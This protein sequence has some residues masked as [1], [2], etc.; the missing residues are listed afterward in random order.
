MKILPINNDP[1]IK[2]YT[3]HTYIDAIINNECTTGNQI[4]TIELLEEQMDQLIYLHGDV[5][6]KEDG[7]RI[8]VLSDPYNLDNSFTA[9]RR[10]K[11]T[12]TFIIGIEYQQ[13][14]NIW[15]NIGIFITDQENIGKYNDK[16]NFLNFCKGCLHTTNMKLL[17]LQH[18][19]KHRFPLYLKLCKTEGKL[20]GF[21]SYDMYSWINCFNEMVD[22]EIINNYYIGVN[23]G[24]SDNHYYN[25]LFSNYIQLMLSKSW[26]D[27]SIIPL[28]FYVM[29]Q[30]DYKFQTIHNLV[31]FKNENRN[32]ITD[33]NLNIIDY[34]IIQLNHDNYVEVL[35]NERYIPGRNGYLQQ[36]DRNHPN[37]IYGYNE[38]DKVFY[39]LGYNKLSKPVQDIVPFDV[40]QQAYDTIG[41]SSDIRM[42]EY[43]PDVSI[44]RM[45]VEEIA[46]G[47]KSYLN[48]SNSSLRYRNIIVPVQRT[49]GIDI[50][51]EFIRDESTLYD[52]MKDK[53]ISYILF[54][55]KKI[56]RD[57]IRYLIKREVLIESEH[58][59]IDI[60]NKTDQIFLISSVIKNLVIKYHSKKN[61]D[62]M[63]RIKEYL[64]EMRN[65]E[66]DCYGNLYELLIKYLGFQ[67][68]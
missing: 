49:F 43:S 32:V 10:I 18:Y 39:I 63:N 42:I 20:S 65:M 68:V 4:A 57:R 21:Y 12:D 31:K 55:H 50:Y 16:Y 29:P 3:H 41:E 7:N 48:G 61:D 66:I 56:M 22:D 28:D 67:Y 26:S 11:E 60:I 44:F 9:Y 19:K 2:I 30:R 1:Y 52:F 14:V 13:Y 40:F 27:E 23:I 15:G 6:I 54:E 47:I 33:F 35:L 17:N 24:L 59:T 25:W 46:E 51:D 34:I 8:S 36:F 64:I 58:S 37:L 62:Y 45:D 5:E 38:E 53:R